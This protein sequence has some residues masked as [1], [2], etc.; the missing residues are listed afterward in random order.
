MTTTHTV[1]HDYVTQSGR[2]VR[3]KVTEDG[4]LTAVMDFV[5]DESGRPVAT[6]ALSSHDKSCSPIALLLP[7]ARLPWL[8][9]R[10]RSPR[11]P[12]A[13]LYST[14]GTAFATYYYILNLQGD[15]VK[16]IGTDGTVAASYTYDAW[17]NILDASGSMAEKNSLRYRGYYYDSETGYYYLQSR[18]Y[19]PANRRF[20]NADVYNSTSQGFVGTNMFAY[21]QNNPICY[22]DPSGEFSILGWLHDIWK[23]GECA[24]WKGFAKILKKNGYKLTGKLLELAAS[25]GGKYHA[26]AN[27]QTSQDIIK[28]KDFV[29]DV[30]RKYEESNTTWGEFGGFWYEFPLSGDLGAAL[31]NVSYSFRAMR[32]RRTNTKY[33]HV[34]ITDTFDFTEFKNPLTQ[35]SLKS[36]ILWI[37]NDVAYI[38]S[39]WNLIDP[40]EVEIEVIIVLD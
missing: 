38:D 29:N 30:K 17:G 21:C 23:E 18:Y 14:N 20:I 4:T 24:I 22:T 8:R 11:S 5:Y 28:Q 40:V 32:D 34:T 35:K 10:R 15:V 3:E 25:G 1:Q 12:L 39:A 7:L 36:S 31:H 19:D 2:L 6:A 26:G 33:L 9:H 13:V 16:L 37:A 27:S